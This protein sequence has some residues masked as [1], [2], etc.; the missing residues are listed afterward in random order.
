MDKHKNYPLPNKYDPD[1][2]V[3]AIDFSGVDLHYEGLF[4]FAN[5][6]RIE[7][8]SLKGNSLLDDW[9]IDKL[10]TMFTT[11]E[12]LDISECKLV[13][14]RGL[15]ALYRM[16]TLKTLKVTNWH[17]SEAMEYTCLL[18]EDVNPNL[19]IEILPPPEKK[20]EEKKV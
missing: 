19:T 9:S 10:S 12:Y 4:C 11:L 5:L 6:A 14:E 15:E 8:L 13:S 20:K 3:E 2:I 16:N 1:Y 17:G 18:L 7:W